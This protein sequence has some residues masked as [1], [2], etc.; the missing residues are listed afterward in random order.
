MWCR[1][2][3]GCGVRQCRKLA[4]DIPS[5]P[6]SS[7]FAFPTVFSLFQPARCEAL[8]T[9]VVHL[10]LSLPHLPPLL[11]T[12]SCQPPLAI[13]FSLFQHHLF[14]HLLDNLPCNRKREAG[15]RHGKPQPTRAVALH[16]PTGS[17]SSWFSVEPSMALWGENTGGPELGSRDC[18]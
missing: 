14:S 11:P 13:F 8:V 4:G 18:Q 12:L 10:S 9:V 1:L 15:M 5:P 6:L 3:V 17:S 7:C 2:Q 16:L